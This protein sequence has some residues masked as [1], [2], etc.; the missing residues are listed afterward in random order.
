MKPTPRTREEA[1]GT[2]ACI[3]DDDDA[4]HI[5]GLDVLDWLLII[6]SGVLVLWTCG[7]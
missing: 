4:E 2:R 6:A 5:E 3:H 1:F 7:C